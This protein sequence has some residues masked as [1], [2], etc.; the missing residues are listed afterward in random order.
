[1][2]VSGRTHDPTSH[3]VPSR[4]IEAPYRETAMAP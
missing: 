4:T 1:M 3:H 2:A